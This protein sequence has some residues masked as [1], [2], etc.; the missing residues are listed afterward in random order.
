M[1]NVV[2]EFIVFDFNSNKEVYRFESDTRKKVE[3]ELNSI[4][5]ENG[6]TYKVITLGTIGFVG[7]V[8]EVPKDTGAVVQVLN[9]QLPEN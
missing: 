3:E 5:D 6:T 8:E 4:K 7:E 9:L 2:Y 1:Q